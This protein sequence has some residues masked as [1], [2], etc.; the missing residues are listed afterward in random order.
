MKS[1]PAFF[2]LLAICAKSV[3]AQTP[4][5]LIAPQAEEFILEN[6]LQVVVVPD[7]R[8][9][10]VTHMVWYKIGAADEVAGK[11]GLAHFLE[12]LMF[13]G[14]KTNPS[15][16]FS[17]WLA[18]IGGQ[19]NAFT[20]HDYTAY[21]QRT[22]KRFLPQLMEFEADR[23]TGLILTDEVVLPERDVI[24]EE[25]RQ[26][27]EQRPEAL[28]GESM[29]ASLYLNHPYGTPIIGWLH[30]MQQLTSQDALEFYARYYTPNNAI[31]VVAGDVTTQEVR[32]LTQKTYGKVER[33]AEPPARKRPIEP[34]SRAARSVT[35]QDARVKQVAWSRIYL[36]PS[37]S[38]QKKAAAPALELLE[39]I[40]G[41]TT[42]R[43]YQKLV[44]EKG[45]AASSSVGYS[46][47]GLDSGRFSI[48]VTPKT[49]EN[50]AQIEAEIAAIIQDIADNGVKAEELERARSSLLANSIYAED[51]QTYLARLF[52]VGLTIGLKFEDIRTWPQS[53][54]VV[55]PESVR[56]AAKNWLQVERSVT[57]ILTMPVTQPAKIQAEKSEAVIP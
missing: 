12:H 50:F 41:G 7:H 18:T 42:G 40:L 54:A 4:M 1:F 27:I 51:S 16:Q 43:F 9:P 52:G 25:R 33:R 38:S 55:T 57:G 17:K 31:L 45:I 21:F 36:V 5:D 26:V 48:D 6:G 53:I 2:I 23:M 30:E 37:Y 56:E 20:A 28:L 32:E 10:V 22:E 24:M 34:L 49:S 15:G 3:L 46:G 8:T 44:V 29:L 11:S 39:E 13:K 19:E 14:T 47:Q 35:L